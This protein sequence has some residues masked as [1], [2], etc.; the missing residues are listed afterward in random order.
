MNR[1]AFVVSLAVLLVSG[2]NAQNY[3]SGRVC[4]VDGSAIEILN[5]GNVSYYDR[6]GNQT[7]S[8][9][10]DVKGYSGKVWLNMD[11]GESYEGK[12]YH[13]RGIA[14]RIDI[15]RTIYSMANCNSGSYEEEETYNQE[16]VEECDYDCEENKKWEE[17]QR[18]R[19]EE[20]RN[21]KERFL[22]DCASVKKFDGG[23]CVGGCLGSSG[24][25]WDNFKNQCSFKPNGT[26][27]ITRNGSKIKGTYTV[28]VGRKTGNDIEKDISLKME[29]GEIIVGYVRY[30]CSTDDSNNIE[31][32][33]R[34]AK[35]GGTEYKQNQ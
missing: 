31:G 21:E 29:N 1:I 10:Y 27:E 18:V 17:E 32:S 15:K 13:S 19:E 30:Y 26:V 23:G 2:V 8:G 5:N 9:S 3:P 6:S 4:G 14:A 24:V 7:G 22:G 12:L 34:Y 35:L 25:L 33:V 16:E 28:T 11:N 20:E